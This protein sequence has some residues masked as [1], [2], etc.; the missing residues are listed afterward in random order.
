MVDMV[1]KSGG[2]IGIIPARGGSKRIHKKNIIPFADGTPMICRTIKAALE[3]GIMDA[4][5][6]STDDE[7]IAEISRKA[8]AEVPFLRTSAKDDFAPVSE[9]TLS[10]LNEY[11]QLTGK[12]FNTVIQLMANC[13][14]RTSQDIKD[15]YSDFLKKPSLSS[16][17]SFKYGWMNPWWA[18]KT[19]KEGIAKALLPKHIRFKRSQDLETLF[20]P[21]GATWIS[22]TKQLR[23]HNSFYTPRYRFFS[24]SWQSAIDIDDLED[25][26]MAE[27]IWHIQQTKK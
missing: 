1:K 24:I 3:S 8:G 16:I 14:L 27:A 6:V 22:E 7:E 17:S 15:Q 19:N 13:P 20:C 11:E 4:V 25:L 12:K 10:T 21:S 23:K 26:E 5:V 2:V 18:H 9:A